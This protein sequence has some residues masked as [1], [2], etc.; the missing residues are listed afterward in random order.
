M[1]SLVISILG[2]S[3]IGIATNSLL[4][5]VG[6]WLCLLAVNQSFIE[7]LNHVSRDKDHG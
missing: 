3:L 7:I 1:Y 2:C 6:L 5:A 4:I